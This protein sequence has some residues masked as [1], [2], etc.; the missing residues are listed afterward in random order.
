M[1]KI[2]TQNLTIA[3]AHRHLVEGD[4]SAVELAESYLKEIEEKDTKI[5]AYLEVFD[6][7][8]EQAK[9]AD[10]QIRSEKNVSLLTGIPIALKDNILAEGRVASAGSKILDGYTAT[11][12][13]T[14]VSKLKKSG[15]VF[16]GR[17]NLDEFAMGSSTEN[18]AFGVTKNPYD[19]TRVPGGSSGGSTAAVSYGGALVAL[20]SDTG[21]SIRQPASFCGVVGLKPTYGAVSRHGLIAMGSSL[22]QIGPIGRSVEDVEALWGEIRGH[23][24][25]DSTSLPETILQRDDVQEKKSL[26]LGVPRHFFEEG[27]D[28]DV[29]DNFNKTISELKEK[30][31]KIKDIDLGKVRHSLAVYYIVMPAEASTNLA[32]YDGVKYGL[33]KEGDDL[34]GDYIKTR[35]EGFGREVRRR[36]LLGTYVLSAGY[37][38]AYYG[39]AI[40]LRNG[41]IKDF[42]KAFTEVDAI[43]TPTTP[44][45]AFSI[46][47]KSDPLS[48]YLSDI[49]TAPTNLSGMPAISIPSGT[50]VRGGKDLPL[51]IQIMAPNLM[52]NML[53]TIGKDVEAFKFK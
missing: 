24:S 42:E 53:F 37:F 16:L 22:D 44:T 11:Y 5:H 30:G 52:E 9:S 29:L 20:G 3:K 14:V 2:D 13:S 39:K 18:S 36:I 7:V 6:D 48:M 41:I 35:A 25:M 50:A 38:D 46:G 51:G 17:T 43:V 28:E 10:L 26:T 49:F 34:L 27:I 4:F 47:E 45:P 19:I 12:D 23:D 32:R 31:Y 15:A 33:H 1:A 21:G 8:K 40:A